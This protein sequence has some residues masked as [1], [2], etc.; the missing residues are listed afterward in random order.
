[1]QLAVYGHAIELTVNATGTN[2]T[3]Q[4]WKDGNTTHI[5]N[6]TEFTLEDN[7]KVSSLDDVL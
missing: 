5:R 3:Y 2:L 6:T 1:M 7:N 4:W